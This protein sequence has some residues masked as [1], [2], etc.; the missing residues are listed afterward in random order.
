ME[1]DLYAYDAPDGR[2]WSF[3]PVQA[4][5][6]DPVAKIEGAPDP[7]LG[8]PHRVARVRVPEGTRVDEADP[9]VLMV[10]GLGRVDIAGVMTGRA[11]PPEVTILRN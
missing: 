6:E 5:A 4:R 7:D 1:L 11:C 10:P 3:T 9:A 2:R 8:E